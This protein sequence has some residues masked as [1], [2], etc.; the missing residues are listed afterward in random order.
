MGEGLELSVEL[1]LML[2]GLRGKLELSEE[3]MWLV[4]QLAVDMKS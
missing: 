3:L 1:H 4:S 2:E